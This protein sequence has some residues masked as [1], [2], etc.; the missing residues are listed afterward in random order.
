MGPVAKGEWS[1][2]VAR[3]ITPMVYTAAVDDLKREARRRG[4]RVAVHVCIDTGIGR[5]GVPYH[6][7]MPYLQH[8]TSCPEI[9][10]AGIMMTFTEDP[11]FDRVQLE[12][13]ESLCKAAQKSGMSLGRRHAA[14]SFALFQ[15]PASFL[16]QVRPGMAI[17]GVYS[18]PE[19][20]KAGVLE[21]RPAMALKCRVVYV[22]QLRSG[23]SAGYNRAF[24]ADRPVWLVTLP[25]GHS[26]GW[27]RQAA[28]GAK[29]RIGSRLYPVVGSVSAS[30]TLVLL[31]E[32]SGV[33][34]GDEAVLFDW[35]ENS[36]PEDVGSACGV[37]V[38]D[39]TMHLSPL[40]PRFT[41]P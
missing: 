17:F 16:D 6:Q 37:S 28:K 15:N 32:E 27:P 31:G 7:A 1:E 18:E 41:F 23:D 2:V 33:K 29:V 35:Q 30:H 20:R 8:L 39:L 36:R 40:L 9:A 13:F 4:K 38:Y 19:F 12:R 3:K 14:S 22:K 11:E 34:I 10:I 26:D 24:K 21:L 5:V 25:I